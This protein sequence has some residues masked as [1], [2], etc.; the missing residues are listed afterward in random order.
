MKKLLLTS[1][2]FLCAQF[3]FAQNMVQVKGVVYDADSNRVL[4]SVTI[5]VKHTSRIMQN[6]TDGSFSIFVKPTDTLIFG[7]YGFRVK[8]LC[9][10]DSSGNK[11]YNIKVRMSHLRDESKEV[12][13]SEARTQREVRRDIQS[14][15]MAHAYALERPNAIQSPISAIYD[16]Y[17]K[18]SQSKQLLQEYEFELAKN[19]LVKQLLDIYNKQ[20]IINISPSD[21]KA[22][23]SNLNLDWE[24]LVVASDYDLA[25]YIKQKALQWKN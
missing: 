19:K 13:I 2:C 8:Y 4:D 9:F 25:V 1:L 7:L 6:N 23:V 15:V 10:K 16:Q 5:I 18:K 24:F 20:G 17:S 12:V 3:L 11:D 14:L 21:Y 22:F